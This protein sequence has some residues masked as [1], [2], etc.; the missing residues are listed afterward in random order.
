MDKA[1]VIL[2]T[3]PKKEAAKLA[4]RLLEER[5]AACVNIVSEVNSLFWWDGKIDSSRETLLIVKSKEAFLGEVVGLVKSI[6]SYSIPEIIAL[7]VIGG[8]EEYLSWINK[9]V[10]K[11][12]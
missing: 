6:H 5:L 4:N 11:R 8:N 10:K 7:P 12:S 1:V 2:I 9:C 3:S